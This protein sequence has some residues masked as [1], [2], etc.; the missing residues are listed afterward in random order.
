MWQNQIIGKILGFAGILINIDIIEIMNIVVRK[1]YRNQGI[2]KK[3]LEELIIISKRTNLEII[4][5]EVNI[6][7]EIAIKLYKKFG[8]EQIGIRKKY[9]NMIDDAIIMQKKLKY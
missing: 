7:N 6:K 5:L 4:N 3:L 1:E 8:F 2:G 9:Y